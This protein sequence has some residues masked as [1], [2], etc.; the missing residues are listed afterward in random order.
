MHRLHG[1]FLGVPL[2]ADL[3]RWF[4]RESKGKPLIL[5]VLSFQNTPI[6]LFVCLFVQL[7]YAEIPHQLDSS[8]DMV[9]GGERLFARPLWG[10]AEGFLGDLQ[11]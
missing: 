7:R 2:F 3:F 1:L 9:A 8:V 10:S 5:G 4:I 11:S 6:C